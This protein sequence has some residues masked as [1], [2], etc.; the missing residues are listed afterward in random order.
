[1]EP[2]VEQRRGRRAEETAQR[3]RRRGNEDLSA[4][5]R[6][7]I[8]AEVQADADR[9]G[10]QLR[11]V[12]DDGNRMYQLTKLDDYDPVEGV[13]PVLVG[14]NKDGSP[15]KAHLLAKPKAYIAEDQALREASRKDQERAFVTDPNAMQGKGA[16]PNPGAGAHYVA[17]GSK[18]E[19]G[20]GRR[21]GNQILEP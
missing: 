15:I 18:I 16:N 14:Q 4:S 11:W 8:P 7:A 2:A 10:L 3:R 5:A 20:E 12:N 19:T 17:K 1:M 21:G 6:M 9:N 13:E